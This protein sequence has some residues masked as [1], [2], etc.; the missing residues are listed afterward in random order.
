M[1]IIPW[2]RDVSEKQPEAEDRNYSDIVTQ[3]LVDAATDNLTDAYVSALEIAAGQLSR[4]F[5]AA[6]VSGTGAAA[7]D[8]WTMAQIGRSLVEG[9]EAVW[10]RVGRRL[11]RADN[12]E[13]L[14]TGRYQLSLAGGVRTK[15]ARRVFHARWNV[16][17]ASGRGLSPLGAART[18]RQLMQ[19]LEGSLATEGNAAVGYLLPVPSDGAAGN[20][21]QLKQDLAALQGRIAVVETTR[22]GWG[23]GQSAAP[24]RDFDLARLGPAYPEGNVRLFVAARES[25][26]AACGYPVQLA[27]DSDGTAQREAWRRYLHGTVAPLGR[28]VAREAQR[29]GL[30]I[31]LDWDALFASDIAGRARAFQS[32]VGGGM[33][34][35]QAAAAAGLLMEED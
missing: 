24:R 14:P 6:G 7:F 27:Q 28:I 32:L 26:L 9:G 1:A 22:Q 30:A 19:R 13:I 16:D 2:K 12:Y 35:A 17:T 10:Y 25:V 11:M 5:A 4:A 23:E 34:I 15:D 31:A 3:A 8:T 29:V 20:I 18:L 33:D 21:E